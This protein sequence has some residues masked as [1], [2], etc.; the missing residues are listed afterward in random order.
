MSWTHSGE[1]SDVPSRQIATKLIEQAH[2][3]TLHGG[4]GL[5]VTK[6]REE[7]WIPGLRRLVKRVIKSC[8]GC[9]RFQTRALN[10]APPGLLPK[11]RTQGSMAFEVV[12]VDFAG[13]IRYRHRKD[14]EGK[15]YLILFTCSLSRALHLELLL[16]LEMVEFVRWLNW[17]AV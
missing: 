2:R 13:P 16:C 4:M 8:S 12:G 3:T 14:Q 1:L 15:C 6:I 9:K 5:T 17:S 10:S 7:C 11:E